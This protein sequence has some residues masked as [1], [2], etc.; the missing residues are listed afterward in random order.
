MADPDTAGGPGRTV[1]SGL[2]QAALPEGGAQGDMSEIT[3]GMMARHVPLI[4]EAGRRDVQILCLQEIFNTPYFC[5]SQ[6]SAWFAAA[7]PVPGPTTERIAAYAP[8]ARH[9]D[10]GSPVR[11]GGRRRF[12]TTRRR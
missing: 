6:D 12:S 2:I 3:A 11:E 7:E 8:P 1:R 4:E 5:P 10:R 9:G